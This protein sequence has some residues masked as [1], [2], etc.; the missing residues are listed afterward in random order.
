M[1]NSK[2]KRETNNLRLK[3][4]EPA[5]ENRHTRS[6]PIAASL[7]KRIDIHQEIRCIT[8][9]A[10]A[11]YGRIVTLMNLLLFST[12]T[13]DAWLLDRE[14][15]LALCLCRAGEPQPFRIIDTPDTFGIDW[16][17]SF[18]IEGAAFN[19]T[20]RSGRVVEILGYPTDE[21]SEACQR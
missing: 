1:S 10:Q 9:L 11:E 19:V 7:I 4:E 14:D 5:R 17:A 8:E 20:E 13:G 2:K 12:H 16:P 6:G 3:R 15:D 21:I 18:A